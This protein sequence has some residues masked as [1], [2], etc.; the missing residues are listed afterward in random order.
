MRGKPNTPVTLWVERK[1]DDAASCAS[2]SSA[3]SFG[4]SQVEHKLLDKGVGYIKV[5]QFSKGISADVADAM[6]EM[7][8]KGATRWILDL[9][10]NPGGLL[11]EAVQLSDL[12]VDSRHGRDDRVGSRSRSAPRRARLRRHDVAARGARQRRLGVGVG[13]RRRRA[14]EP[15]PR[16]HH[17]HAHVRQGLGPGALRQRGSQQA[18]A[19]DRA[20]PDA[21]RSLDPEPRHRPRH[22][23]PADVRPRQE[24]L[25]DRLR[26]PA[27]ADAHLRREGS[28]RAPRVDVREG[29]RQADVRG[30]V[31]RRA[32]EEPAAGEQPR[33]GAAR[34]RRRA[35]RG[36][37]RRGLRDAV[38]E[39]AASRA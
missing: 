27:R 15:R 18:Q 11:E 7:S 9:R 1:G 4:V 31:P 8:G 13:D 28:R 14:Q 23:A 36:R 10:Y 17:R 3:T 12:F 2:I 6:K 39:G 21:R 16:R 37:D 25:A 22:P 29:H 32:Q 30:A 20:V 24:R 19:D 38:R 5:K 33:D 34:R 35:R 26:A